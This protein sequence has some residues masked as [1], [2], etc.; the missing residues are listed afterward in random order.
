MLQGAGAAQHVGQRA[1]T[2][3]SLYA[4]EGAVDRLQL[5]AAAVA[6]DGLGSGSTWP[7]A[8]WPPLAVR[9]A[10]RNAFR[11]LQ[12]D[13]RDMPQWFTISLMLGSTFRDCAHA[14][15]RNITSVWLST[16]AIAVE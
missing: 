7:R 4:M 11:Y 8:H 9:P 16:P 2:K 10:L 12:A 1:P 15:K 5:L 3:L 14:A 13:A 6:G